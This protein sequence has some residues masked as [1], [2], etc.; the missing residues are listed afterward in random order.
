MALYC[1]IADRPSDCRQIVAEH[2]RP[3][4][5]ELCAAD[6]LYTAQITAMV[7]PALYCAHK[8]TAIEQAKTLPPALRDSA[9][10]RIC[11]FILTKTTPSE[12]YE[13]V[14]GHEFTVTYEEIVDLCELLDLM[15]SDGGIYGFI[16][17]IANS[18]VSRRGSP[19]SEQQK[20]DIVRRLDTVISHKFPSH[21]N[22]QHAGYRIAA[23]A[24][25]A[26]IRRA[27]SQDWLSLI[28]AARA[29][30]NLAD[31]AL[32]V[33]MVAAAM[34]SREANRRSAAFDEARELI[35]HIPS[36]VDRVER[37]RELASMAHGLNVPC[38]REC[39]ELAMRAAIGRDTQVPRSIYRSI[40][41][42]A[43][44]L[45]PRFAASLVSLLDSDPARVETRAN[46]THSLQVLDL[47]K[48][49]MKPV[50][51]T[52]ETTPGVQ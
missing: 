6:T 4:L 20:L 2:V 30:P 25:T 45:D 7:A 8:L 24:Q 27:G 37:Y 29:V 44:M 13:A 15:D 18:V 50:E 32:V 26:R 46:L 16:E 1:H 11:R 23:T 3:L 34:P 49:G 41:D 52:S 40:V 17:G 42:T 43:H 35:G 48:A 12:P 51:R 31:R 33:G 21:R 10:S 38:A 5:L 9:Y 39:L 19:L 14:A 47:K 28:Q 22:I 36:T